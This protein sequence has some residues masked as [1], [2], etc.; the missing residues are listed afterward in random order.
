METLKI[1][2]PLILDINKEVNAKAKE[3]GITEK[4][5]VLTNEQK[6]KMIDTFEIEVIEGRVNDQEAKM[7]VV[8]YNNEI[9][10]AMA[11]LGSRS[12]NVPVNQIEKLK[13]EIL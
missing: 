5:F 7:E 12:M 10:A 4:G 2:L 1:E 3:L 9:L 11:F 6:Q 13:S 8:K